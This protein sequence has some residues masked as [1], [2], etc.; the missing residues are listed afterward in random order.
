MSATIMLIWDYDT[1]TGFDVSYLGR[2]YDPMCEYECTDRILDLLSKHR[3]VSTFAC[4][5]RAAEPGSL[6]YH[7]PDQIRAI[8]QAGHEIA[9]HSHR[10]EF[11]PSLNPNQL[12]ETLRTSKSALEDCTG[13]K[14]VGFVPPWNQPFHHPRKLAI[15]LSERK[16]G[17]GWWKQSVVTLCEALNKCGY[18]WTRVTYATVFEKLLEKMHLSEN[19][20]FKPLEVEQYH[21]VHALPISYFGYD[22]R[23]INL[24]TYQLQA[25]QDK[26]FII[27]AHPHGIE[28]NNNQNWEHLVRFV[29]WFSEYGDAGNM[30]FTTPK[31][32]LKLR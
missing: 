32:W 12:L 30:S 16:A 28:H 2:N 1:P 26:A 29:K 22:G 18:F 14:V 15:S 10:H 20:R 11:I 8:Y 5:G 21:S 23:L 6:P 24:L 3:I 19:P 25:H 27:Y 7:N 9:S 4:V 17:G 13:D 31:A